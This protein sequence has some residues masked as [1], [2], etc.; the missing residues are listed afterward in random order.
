M[1]VI[2][3]YNSKSLENLIDHVYLAYEA[4]SLSVCWFAEGAPHLFFAFRITR[5]WGIEL[6][7]FL[8]LNRTEDVQIEYHAINIR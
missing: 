5:F 2:R 3:L 7:L 4:A 6:E 1:S 8:L